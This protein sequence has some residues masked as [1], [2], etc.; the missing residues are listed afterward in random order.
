[1]SDR[2]TFEASWI[3]ASWRAFLML[4]S[5]FIPDCVPH[6]CLELAVR[7]YRGTHAGVT[8]CTFTCYAA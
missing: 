2:M 6:G 8:A 7:T 5:D 3:R 1:M 4:G